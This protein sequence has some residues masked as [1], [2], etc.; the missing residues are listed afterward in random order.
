[1]A[2]AL[3][4]RQPIYSSQLE[5]LAYELLFRNDEVNRALITDGDRA[6]AKVILNTFME[7]GLD[8]IVGDRK[9]FI[10]FTRGF[11]VG[12]HCL[13]L[14]KER[15]VLEVLE[16]VKPD[17]EVI[18][19]LNTLAENGYTIALD[20]FTYSKELE[21]FVRL[22][23]I[24]KIDLMASDRSVLKEHVRELRRFDVKLLAE[25]VETHEDF[26][27]CKELGFDY[28]QGYFFCKPNTVVGQHSAVNRVA[29]LRLLAKLQESNVQFDELERIISQDPTLSYKLLR[30]VNSA[31]YSL[32]RKLESIN[33]ATVFVGM[34]R[35]RTWSSILMLASMEDKP[36]ELI[37]T[38]LVRARMSELLASALGHERPE[39]LFT[40]GLFSVLDA[41]FDRPMEEI[42]KSIPLAEE[43]AHA[44]LTQEGPVGDI[45]RW[46]LAYEA[47]NWDQLDCTL[48]ARTLRNAYLDSVGWTEKTSRELLA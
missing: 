27:Y 24:I 34:Q 43:I 16:D 41:M 33:E 40:V 22:A 20:D 10:N 35:I 7:I 45:L 30:Y 48:D 18:A 44:L 14:P 46:V 2:E 17:E 12:N 4:G 37:V 11:I 3:V 36:R 21:P 39:R 29:T 28:Y 6:T 5:V 26:E 8:Q 31:V 9:A 15:V 32:A 25:K 23:N 1:M 47:G 42:L 19:A 38:A 13:S